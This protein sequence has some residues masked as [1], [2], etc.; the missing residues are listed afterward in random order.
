[1]PVSHPSER[2]SSIPASR[3]G[4]SLPGEQH[5]PMTGTHPVSEARAGQPTGRR[6]VNSRTC[7]TGLTE[8]GIREAW[9][10]AGAASFLQP[11]SVAPL[12]R[13]RRRA[14]VGRGRVSARRRHSTGVGRPVRKSRCRATPAECEVA[15]RVHHGQRKREH[16]IN[17][18]QP[19]ISNPRC[20]NPESFHDDPTVGPAGGP[21]WPHECQRPTAGRSRSRAMNSAARAATSMLRSCSGW[22]I[23]VT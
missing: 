13:C 1:M 9:L 4:T 18:R 2:M 12:R 3:L 11:T 5:Q 21:S 17:R 15:V 14:A 8:A 16:S 10:F 22:V 23:G 19:L 20:I 7:C 6:R